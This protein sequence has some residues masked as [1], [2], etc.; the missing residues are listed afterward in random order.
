MKGDLVRPCHYRNHAQPLRGR[1]R[2]ACWRGLNLPCSTVD[3]AT[4]G[5]AASLRRA[6]RRGWGHAWRGASSFGN[7]PPTLVVDTSGALHHLRLPVVGCGMEPAPLVE[8]ASAL[9]WLPPR[10]TWIRQLVPSSTDE[11]A[12]LPFWSQE[13]QTYWP[14]VWADERDSRVVP[15]RTPM[16]SQG[17]GKHVWCSLL[18]PGPEGP[19]R[20]ELVVLRPVADVYLAT[21]V[22][23][24]LDER[25]GI[26][27]PDPIGMAGAPG[28]NRPASCTTPTTRPIEI[29]AGG[30]L[31]GYADR[32]L[33]LKAVGPDLGAP[34]SDLFTL[35]QEFMSDP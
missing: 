2:V 18:N 10:V 28:G 5:P 12:C 24:A 16:S 11:G 6:G 27:G 7:E 22:A 34:S 19:M 9:Q 35:V 23:A 25:P 3:T 1:S 33:C 4:D 15:G 29:V 14:Y 21:R 32:G 26:T 30:Q 8:A 13:L 17:V 31:L 20:R